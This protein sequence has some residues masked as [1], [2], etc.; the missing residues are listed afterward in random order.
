MSTNN[1]MKLLMFITMIITVFVVAIVMINHSQNTDSQNVALSAHPPLDNQPTL[2]NLNSS[3]SVVEFSDFKCPACKEWNET[4]FP[5]LKRE[6]IDTGK[7]SFSYVNVLFHGDESALAALASETIWHQ[8]E[9]AFW[10][11][12]KGLYKEQPSSNTTWITHQKL[13]EVAHAT[14]PS[15]DLQKFEQDLVNMTYL[16]DVIVDYQLVEEYGVNFTPSIIINGV[17]L[18]NPFD[19]QQITEL[20][21]RGLAK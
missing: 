18:E 4:I 6:F 2:G 21:E 20:I 17:L 16:D 11:F 5:Q 13:I 10:E 15:I 8:S 1:P 7:I 19:Y 12:K 9:E 14:V 3:V